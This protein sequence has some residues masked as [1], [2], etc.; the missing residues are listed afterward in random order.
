MVN[1]RRHA[2]TLIEL[3]VVVAIIA[4]LMAILLPSLSGAREQA[5]STACLSNQRQLGTI[6]NMYISENSDYVV[7]ALL[8][9]WTAPGTG[10]VR[11]TWFT[12]FSYSGYLPTDTPFLSTLS[13]T[14]VGTRGMLVCPSGL[15]DHTSYASPA[16][17]TETDAEG[18][19]PTR[20]PSKDLKPGYSLDSWY[21][22]STNTNRYN[23]FGTYAGVA[24]PDGTETTNKAGVKTSQ[25]ADTTQTALFFDGI[26][27]NVAY[28]PTRINARHMQQKV[29]NMV[30]V[31]GHA[32]SLRRSSMPV[33]GADFATNILDQKFPYPKWRIN[34]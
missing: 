10:D 3:L 9:N 22:M 29:T 34:R 7:P 1:P 20:Q 28:Y 17:I 31:D 12:I 15:S 4:V 18:A 6:S 2:F 30:F 16:P 13:S 24:I 25:I 5:R 26:S 33:L 11:E 21:S 14:K 19:R 23:T 8:V 32:E 27:W